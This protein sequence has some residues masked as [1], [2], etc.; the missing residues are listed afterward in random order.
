ML[1]RLLDNVQAYST[2]GGKVWLSIRFIFRILVLGKAVESAWED[3]QLAFVCNTRQPCCQ[4]MC[5]DKLFPISHVRL[6][7]LQTILVSMPT[8]LYLSHLFFILQIE[9]KF[10]KQEEMLGNMRSRGANVDVHFKT[11]KM[12][13]TA[14]CL[15]PNYGLCEDLQPI[16]CEDPNYCLCE[17]P[18]HFSTLCEDIQPIFIA[19]PHS[20]FIPCE[21]SSTNI[22]DRLWCILVQPLFTQKSNCLP[23]RRS[24]VEPN[25]PLLRT[26]F[27][28]PD[29]FGKTI[30]VQDQRWIAN[31]LFHSGKLWTDLKLW[32]EP[33]VPAL[34]YHQT[35]TPDRFFTHRLMVWMP[36]HLWKV[37]L[38]CP[39]CGKNL[40]GYGV[41]RRARKV[42]DIDRYA[43]DIRVITI[44]RSVLTLLIDK[45]PPEPIDIPTRHWLLSVYG[46]DILSRIGHIKASITSIFCNILKMDSTKQITKKLAGHGR[47]QHSG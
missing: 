25:Q 39:A 27:W 3:E 32:Y 37:R 38:S 40:T 36:Y 20:C 30:P 7:V 46:R 34:I 29:E 28:L 11:V 2:A 8:L 6:W 10:N 9:K 33:P 47:G 44:L 42:L 41:H 22:L 21:Y 1:G 12:K 17:D 23:N 35:P 5:Y 4:N 19:D 13:W 16:L 24:L 15:D 31:T 18:Q 26:S 14:S 43:C 45:E